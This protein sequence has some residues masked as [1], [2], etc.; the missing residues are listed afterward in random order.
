[1]SDNKKLVYARQGEIAIKYPEGGGGNHKIYDL[2][3]SYADSTNNWWEGIT[4]TMGAQAPEFSRDGSR[5]L[6]IHDL[7]ANTVNAATPKYRLCFYDVKSFLLRNIE[8]DPKSE[9]LAS[10]PTMSPDMKQ[11]AFV[12]MR[13]REQQ[14]TPAGI[15]ICNFSD[16][17][18]SDAPCDC[19]L[20]QKMQRA[21]W[22][23]R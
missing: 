22:Y 9:L 13:I 23:D 11:V 1:M 15:A 4:E 21:S 2:F 8:F 6:F 19:A 5:V 16:F 20:Q 10:T 3:M 14:F 12:V 18:M 7:N 17:P